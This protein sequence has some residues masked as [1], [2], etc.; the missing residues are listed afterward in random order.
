MTRILRR[1]L[2]KHNFMV[3]GVFNTYNGTSRT[4]TILECPHCGKKKRKITI[5]KLIIKQDIGA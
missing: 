1:A 2:C 5:N 3:K 4:I